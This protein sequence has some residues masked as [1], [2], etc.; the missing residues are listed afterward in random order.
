MKKLFVTL[1]V[2][3]AMTSMASAQN[4]AIGARFGFGTAFNP[5]LTTQWFIGDISR[6][7]LDLGLRFKTSAVTDSGINVDYPGGGT[8]TGV[9]QWHWFLAG[10]FGFYFGPGL[11]ISFPNWKKLGFGLGGQIGFD[12]QFDAPFQVSFDFRPIYNVAG[13][14]KGTNTD[15]DKVRFFG[16]FDPVFA[17]GLRYTFDSA[18]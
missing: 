3:L 1:A 9:Y 10:G 18:Y 6:L 11:Q 12:Y 15:T 5:E 17:I 7:E 13:G 8:F 2:L 4:N 16:G 14:F